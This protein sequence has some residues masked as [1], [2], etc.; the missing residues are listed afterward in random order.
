MIYLMIV[1]ALSALVTSYLISK[2]FLLHHVKKHYPDSIS[3][4]N[5]KI[6][7]FFGVIGGLLMILP[8]HFLSIVFGGT[9]GGGYGSIIDGLLGTERLGVFSGI[10]VGIFVVALI[11]IMFGVFAGSLIGNALVKIRP[12][13][14]LFYP[15]LLL[16]FLLMVYFIKG[17]IPILWI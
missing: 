9:M 15:F 1:P 13:P 4:Q 6:Y 12:K 10:A 16:V 8:A 2:R 14:Y 17:T 3:T 11:V 5:R 7:L